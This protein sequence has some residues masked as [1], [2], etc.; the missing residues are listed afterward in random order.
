MV[1]HALNRPFRLYGHRGAPKEYP[2]NT[3]AGFAAAIAAGCNALE[4][5]VHLSLD[6]Y[7]VVAH[8]ETGRRMANVDQRIQATPW[9][10]V[11]R[12]NVA[13]GFAPLDGPE[14]KVH[15]PLLSDVLDA[16][17]QVAM[18]V[19]LKTDTP[20]LATATLQV[21][22][23]APA[24]R[25]E[26][27]SLTSFHQRMFRYLRARGYTGPLGMGPLDVLRLWALPVASL[28]DLRGRAAQVPMAQYGIEFAT[29]R[30]IDKAHALGCRVDFWVVNDTATARKLL[31][32][33]ADGLVTDDARKLELAD[34]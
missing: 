20:A 22:E 3:L 25:R 13:H 27:V 7:V 32:I 10:T 2:E 17:P 8:D 14:V 24:D 5:D 28:N 16:F 30:F 11:A 19:D 33:G 26:R 23:R 15:P 12:W 34:R 31:A 29:A 9:H 18:S 21:L 1:L 6:G 4:L